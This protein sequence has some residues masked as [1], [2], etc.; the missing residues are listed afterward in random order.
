MAAKKTTPQLPA[1]GVITVPYG[2]PFYVYAKGVEAY[3]NFRPNGDIELTL[4]DG[5]TVSGKVTDV[6]V[7]PLIDMITGT[8]AQA[9]TMV[10]RIYS[11][12]AL[13]QTLTDQNGGDPV[14]V[15]KLYTAVAVQVPTPMAPNPVA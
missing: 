5:S 14:D 11:P 2:M 8:G 1:P 7:G 15:T 13:V 6:R 12:L 4:D 9:A 3:E 10:S